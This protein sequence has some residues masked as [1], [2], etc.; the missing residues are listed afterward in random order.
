MKQ[1]EMAALGVHI[2]KVAEA[3]AVRLVL[4]WVV[5]EHLEI[6]DVVMEVGEVEVLMFRSAVEVVQV[7]L[8]VV[9][10]VVVEH[11]ITT[12]AALAALAAAEK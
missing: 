1:E 4:E 9:V 2:Y 12:L 10:E 5:Q 7:V 11:L 3:L 6:M 8:L